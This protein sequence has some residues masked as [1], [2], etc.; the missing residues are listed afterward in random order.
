MGGMHA[1]MQAALGRK[2]DLGEVAGIL[3]RD[4]AG[5]VQRLHQLAL[6]RGHARVVLHALCSGQAA[7]TLS[8][9]L[10]PPCRQCS[11]LADACS[12]KEYP[13]E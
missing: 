1:W 11:A 3:V 5:F 13:T 12:K 7:G 2:E 8:L 4:S 6:D 9:A 10:Y